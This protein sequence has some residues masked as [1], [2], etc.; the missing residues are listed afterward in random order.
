M[1]NWKIVKRD[2]KEGVLLRTIDREEYELPS[3][4]YDSVTE[5]DKD[6]N[7][8]K[9][10]LPEERFLA[11]AKPGGRI[12]SKRIYTIKA[13]K[14][15]GTMVQVPLEDQINN[16]VA[17]PQ[18]AIGL[19]FYARRGMN[20]FFDFDTGE[21]AFCPSWD[22]WAKWNSKFDGFC[23]AEHKAITKGD[24]DEPSGFSLGAT[25]SRGWG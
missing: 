10:D 22:C 17:S 3:T 25:T 23:S 11:F 13:E 7:P 14:T 16:N 15:D 9:V 20:V 5:H 21:A 18:N 8:I 1:K 6:G 4:A 24:T 12:G 2:G 19:Q